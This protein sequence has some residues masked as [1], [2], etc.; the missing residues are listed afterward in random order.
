MTEASA[1]GSPAPTTSGAPPRTPTR[2]A[3]V[4]EDG[5]RDLL[6]GTRLG[7]APADAP[8]GT[9]LIVE[10]HALEKASHEPRPIREILALGGTPLAEL[11]TLSAAEGLSPVYPAAVEEEVERLHHASGVDDPSLTDETG[12]PYVTIDGASSRDLDQ[13]ASVERRGEGFVL[14]YA[15]ADAS[16]YAPPGSALFRESLVRAASYYLP[17]LVLPM[18]PRALSEGLVSLNPAVDRRALVFRVE[19]D[20]RGEV[21]GGSVYRARIH[22]RGKLSFSGVQRYYDTG[23]GYTG[24]VAA[25]LEALRALGEARIDRAEERAVVRYRRREVQIDLAGGKR[26]SVVDH[27]RRAVERYN[28]QL[29]LLCNVVGAQ[30]LRA[31]GEVEGVA[32]IYRV[33]PEPA[34]EKLESFERLVHELSAL[35]HLPS[36]TWSW[37]RGQSMAGY[38]DELPDA[39]PHAR[40]AQAIHRQAVMT[41]LRSSFATEARGHH[42]IGADVYARFSAPM[43]EVVGV[44]LHRELLEL[45]G[46]EPAATGGLGVESERLRDAVVDAANEAKLRQKRLTDGAN[47]L[48]IDQLLERVGPETRLRGTLLGL[49]RDRAYVALDEPAIDLKLY[50]RDQP[51]G[52]SVA[53]SLAS[54]SLGERSLRLGDA[55]ELQVLGK[56]PAR[57]R[58]KIAFA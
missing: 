44:Y 13:A 20:S 12:L 54:V 35:H 17:G 22:S 43:R 23:E 55:V 1:G 41:N 2:A 47:R 9:V 49:R 46:L 11:Y 52:A 40:L 8:T 18:L 16:Y 33:H 25:N 24:P 5:L 39:G 48:V 10:G 28:E 56:D 15:L 27:A 4:A 7:P 50:L 51:A 31:G 21:T 34:E 3:R 38:L 32:P 42:G 36:Q 6:D 30:R 53:P 19:L 14:R 57:D 37:R 45:A 58:W 29:S 26:F